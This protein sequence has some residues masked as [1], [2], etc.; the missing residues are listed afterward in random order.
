MNFSILTTLLPDIV[1][2]VQVELSAG[3]SGADKQ[4]QAISLLQKFMTAAGWPSWAQLGVTALANFAIP[5]IVAR[6]NNDTTNTTFVKSA[7]T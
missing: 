3:A 6:F 7:T 5:L 2:L 1:T 4:A